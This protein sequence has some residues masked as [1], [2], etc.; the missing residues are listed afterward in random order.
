MAAGP[1]LRG[2]RWPVRAKKTSSRSGVWTDSRSASTPASSSRSSRARSEP[3]L[4]SL[5]HLQGERVVVAGGGGEERA[6]AVRR[7]S[8]S[9]NCSRMWPPGMRRLSSSARAL[10]DDPAVV[11]HRDP[12][13]QLVGLVQVLRGQEDR[14]AAGH[15]LADDL[16]HGA[17]AARVQPGGR[18]VEEDQPRVADQGHG[19]VEAAPHAA[20]VG[21]AGLRRRVGQ[22][23]L[24]Q[25]LGRAAPA[26]R[27]GPGGAG[28][29]S[30]A[31]SPR[32]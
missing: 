28:R 12:V 30:G 23:E 15:E 4:P 2:C 3:T 25:Q 16:P 21:R 11:Q 14:H 19:Q 26:R 20:G 29:P 10:G 8:G 6:A 17:A 24:V 31:G 9:A 7:A 22:V 27:P 13:G 32:R 1:S 18:L 5:G